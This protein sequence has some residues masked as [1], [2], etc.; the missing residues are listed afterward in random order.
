MNLS[1]DPRSKTGFLSDRTAQSELVGVVLIIGLTLTISVVIVALGGMALEES[2][3]TAELRSAEQAMAHLDSKASLAALGSRTEQQTVSLG[4]RESGSVRVRD[5]GHVVVIKEPLGGGNDTEL[6]DGSV[7]TI[8]YT[9]SNGDRVAYQGGGVWRMTESGSVMVS[10]PEIHFEGKTL[11]MP[12]VAIDTANSTYGGD[13]M[14]L[15]RS[16]G[17]S[18]FPNTNDTNPNTND[19]NPIEDS[20][21]R[22]EIESDYFNGWASYFR[23]RVDASQVTTYPSNETVVVILQPTQENPPVKAGLIAGGNGITSMQGGNHG[24]IDSYNSNTGEYTSIGYNGTVY[25]SG[26]I[27]TNGAGTV[28]GNLVLDYGNTIDNPGDVNGTISYRN[29]DTSPIGITVDQKLAS[30]Q[31]SNDNGDISGCTDGNPCSPSDLTSDGDL[32]PGEYYVDGDLHV[33]SDLEFENGGGDITL[34]VDGDVTVDGELDVE[35]ADDSAGT[36]R[37]FLAGSN[38]EFN[39]DNNAEVG[40]PDDDSTKFW[41]Y[42]DETLEVTMFKAEFVGVIYA[43]RTS[44]SCAGCPDVYLQSNTEVW[45]AIVAGNTRLQGNSQIHYDEALASMQPVPDGGVSRIAYLHITV[46][47][48]RAE[49]A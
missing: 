30:V 23:D 48:L 39:V 6:Y 26:D 45:G 34:V 4:L 19:T 8:E 20:Q 13:R 36:V 18:V 29:I 15:A 22:L 25:S 43:P 35:S 24:M 21:I 44:E 5:T 3:Q 17:S 10:P 40:A 31:G 1:D 27:N 9:G 11:T 2:R 14:R 12:L 46:N 33:G 7:G 42:G 38:R 49:A 37:L 28:H 41:V 16:G 47:E 32:E